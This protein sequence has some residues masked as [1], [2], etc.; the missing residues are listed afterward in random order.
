MRIR[1]AMWVMRFVPGGESV[2][3]ASATGAAKPEDDAKVRL[4]VRFVPDAPAAGASRHEAGRSR[5]RCADENDA[6]RSR[7]ARLLF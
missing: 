6:G 1:A 7:D 2:R 3:R 4:R 5:G